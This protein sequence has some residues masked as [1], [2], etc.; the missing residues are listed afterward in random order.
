MRELS[1]NI[2]DVAE[3]SLK[4]GADTIKIDV[5]FLREKNKLTVRV[6]D[7]GCGMTKDQ[8]EHVTD[9]FFTTRTTRKVGLGVPFFNGVQKHTMF[10]QAVFPTGHGRK[11]YAR[12]ITE[13]LHLQIAN[14]R[15]VAVKQPKGFFGIRLAG[16]FI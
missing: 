8:V 11:L 14:A 10:Q 13:G 16:V 1:L 9:P 12:I 7:N 4:A 5:E 15:L 6:S 2:L 3:N